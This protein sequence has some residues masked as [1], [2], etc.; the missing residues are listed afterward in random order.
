MA[1]QRTAY[2]RVIRGAV[3]AGALSGFTCAGA[4][5]ARAQTVLNLSA[6][7]QADA[8]PDEMV[9]SLQ[10]QETA[11]QAEAAQAAVNAAMT[12]ALGMARAVPGIVATT[13]GYQVFKT[14]AENAATPAQ[15]QASQILAL[16]MP[17][18]GG[19]PPDRFTS[20][21]GQLQQN[22]LL[23][24]TLDGHL[25][26]AGQA[27]AGQAAIADGIGQIQ[28]QAA[29]I[30]ARLNMRV[31]GIKTLD[32]NVNAPMLVAP[33]AML[34]SA[35]APPQAAPDKVTVQANI[36]ATIALTSAQ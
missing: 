20:L 35:M 28:A 11:P 26:R 24:N 21:L 36:S 34:M 29:M 3:L 15:F 17:A 5:V 8:I 9:A 4:L 25:S 16:V 7:G 27:R 10:V 19:V 13:N 18:P 2:G 31:G 30:A 1:V 6:V 33:K 14:A 23:L 22:G 12:K 32:V